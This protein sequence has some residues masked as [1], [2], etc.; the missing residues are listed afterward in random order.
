M[1]RRIRQSMYGARRRH[2]WQSGAPVFEARQGAEQ[3]RH[4]LHTPHL[5]SFK[6]QGDGGS[7]GQSKEGKMRRGKE[8]GR[9]GGR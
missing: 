8:G 5:R 1:G 3:G 2:L 7:R 4:P 9:E 6:R